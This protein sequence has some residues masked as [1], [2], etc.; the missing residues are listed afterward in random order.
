MKQ[1]IPQ[2]HHR[3]G[4]FTLIEMLLVI[5]IIG[6]LAGMVVTSLSG[7]SKEARIT[8]AR[9][10]IRGNLS[11]ALDLFEQDVGRY[12]T[13]DEGLN[14][15]V[16]DPGITG[17]KGPYLKG[18]LMNDPWGKAYN[19]NLDSEN[20]NIYILSSAGPDGQA[21]NDDDIIEKSKSE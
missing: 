16:T 4:G 14:A 13:S 21:G 20:S 17:W 7:R 11:R 15:L 9:A 6:V 10:D 8:R 3:S 19:Y 5:V 1:T 12:P 18:G 2:K